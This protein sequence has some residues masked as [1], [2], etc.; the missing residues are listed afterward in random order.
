MVNSALSRFKVVPAVFALQSTLSAIQ[1]TM[2]FASLKESVLNRA[3]PAKTAVLEEAYLDLD[4]SHSHYLQR[5]RAFTPSSRR[6]QRIHFFSTDFS[7]AQFR[8][9]TEPKRQALFDSYLGYTVIRP[10][11]PQT[12][13]R[14]FIKPPET[15][16]GKK[17]FFPTKGSFLS[18][19]S[20]LQ[21][22]I[23]ACPYLSQDQMVMACATAS[24]WMSSNSLCTKG[25]D[26]PSYSTSDITRLALSLNRTYGP[27]IGGRGLRIEEMEHAFMAM[28]YDPILSEYPQQTNLLESAYLYL[29]SGIPPVL[30][31]FFPE[32]RIH[33]YRIQGLHAVTVVGHTMDTTLNRPLAIINNINTSASFMPNLILNDDQN[34]MYL[35]ADV[36]PTAKKEKPFRAKLQINVNGQILVGYCN[37]ILVPLPPRVLLDGEAAQRAA[38]SWLVFAQSNNW[39]KNDPLV[40]R[41]FLVRANRLKESFLIRANSGVSKRLSEVYR[42]LSMPRYVWVVEYGYYNNWVNSAPANLTIEGEIIIDPTSPKTYKPDFLSMHVPGTVVAKITDKDDLVKTVSFNIPDD[43]PYTVLPIVERP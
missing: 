22:E 40:L 43:H 9:L 19:L 35:C 7:Q 29:E 1:P 32:Q 37:S 31:I 8:S 34:G 41:T 28:G 25:A 15:I 12:L 5:S 26:I 16:Q 36:M 10:G 21:L 33:G 11:S 20:G 38:A 30:T 39:L 3:E 13:G 14:T 17:A 18:N 24:L 42:G 4:Y 27:T 6:T 2:V 23:V